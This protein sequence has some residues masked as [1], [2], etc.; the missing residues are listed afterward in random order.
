MMTPAQTKKIREQCRMMLQR[1]GVV[2][3]DQEAE[4][5]EVADFGLSDIERTGLQLLVYKNTPRY[6]AK[7]L[8]LLPEQTCPEHLH[9]TL[10]DGTPGK[11]ETFRCRYGHVFLYVEGEPCAHPQCTPPEVGREYYTVWHEV[12]LAPGEQYTI[13]P[14]TKH[15]FQAGKNGAVVSEF[16][17]QSFDELDVFTNPSITRVA[18]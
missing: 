18:R 13:P 6:C 10:A 7:D 9:P 1:A 3:T 15:W 8:V 5:L 16:S 11:E 17:S 12:S 2:I 14:N 4:E